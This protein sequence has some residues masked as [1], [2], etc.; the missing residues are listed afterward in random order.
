MKL[1]GKF[2]VSL[3]KRLTFL[4]LELFCVPIIR[5]KNKEILNIAEKRIFLI[6]DIFVIFLSFVHIINLIFSDIISFS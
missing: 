6:I 2:I 3:S 1:I 5:T 4:L